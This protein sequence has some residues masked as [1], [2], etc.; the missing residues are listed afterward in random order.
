MSFYASLA[1]FFLILLF[2]SV[3]VYVL[4]IKAFYWGDKKEPPAKKK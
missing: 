2:V 4:V 3:L 1:V